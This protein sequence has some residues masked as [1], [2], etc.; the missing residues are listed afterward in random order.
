KVLLHRYTGQSDILIGTATAGRNRVEVESLIGHFVNLLVRRTDL[1]GDPTFRELLH[2]VRE[3]ITKS[4]TYQNMPFW[5]WRSVWITTPICSSA[6]RLSA[7]CG[8]SRLCWNP[9][10]KTMTGP[11]QNWTY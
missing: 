6:R 5:N 2:R 1:S 10:P 4:Y 11:F 9:S 7:C 3:E 8:T